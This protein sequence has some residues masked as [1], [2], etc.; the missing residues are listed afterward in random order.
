MT[1]GHRKNTNAGNRFA[2]VLLVLLIGAGTYVA[3]DRDRIARWFAHDVIDAEKA[4][5]E[6]EI[7]S[8]QNKVSALETE[9]SALAPKIP[10]E[11][12][13]EVFGKSGDD[14]STV[15]PE[16]NSCGE[17]AKRLD[18]FF[19]YL[20]GRAYLKGRMRGGAKAYFSGLIQRALDRPPV[21]DRETDDLSRFFNS[22]THFLRVF[23][24]HD[25]AVIRDILVREPDVLEPAFALFYDR[26]DRGRTCGAPV[27]SLE[28]VYEYSAFLLQTVGGRLYVIR[29]S[30]RV[31]Q[32]ARYY[33][34]L[35]LDRANKRGINSHG[36]D[37]RPA[38]KRLM[39]DMT[40][41][42]QL[43]G[44]RDYLERLRELDAYYRKQYG[45]E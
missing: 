1:N 13:S 29:R 21:I 18:A 27:Y 26:I 39:S 6:A 14:P 45:A 41:S 7:S 9:L 15:S 17:I 3:Y 11:R 31:S 43:S 2:I 23:G 44:R 28:E 10:S 8:L 34:L 36:V 37:I 4:P 22:M 33:A 24:K 38:V 42:V 20:D 32:L 16:A 19:G 30:P 35:V 25:L 5:L 40:A 12:M